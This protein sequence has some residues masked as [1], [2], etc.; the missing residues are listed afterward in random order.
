MVQLQ[1]VASWC[2]A[3]VA[4]HAGPA[5]LAVASFPTATRREGWHALAAAT[6]PKLAACQ[7]AA[8]GTG[9]AQTAAAL[10]SLPAPFRGGASQRQAACQ[11]LLQ[12]AALPDGGLGNGGSSLSAGGPGSPPAGTAAAV[13]G[14]AV[15]LSAPIWAAPAKGAVSRFY[16]RTASDG[17]PLLL[18]PPGA[19]GGAHAAAVGDALALQIEVHSDLPAALRLRDVSLTLGVLQEMTGG[20]SWFETWWFETR[21][22]PHASHHDPLSMHA[23]C[24]PTPTHVMQ[25]ME[26]RALPAHLECSHPLPTGRLPA[27]HACGCAWQP[28]RGA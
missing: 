10:L 15:D 16:G 24:A 19:P 28:R 22:F 6:L 17:A 20:H 2:H 27:C 9:L 23:A 25:Q 18:L 7:L 26:Q 12:A 21:W 13:A 4:E 14:R 8:G 3:V 5:S 1:S 11:L